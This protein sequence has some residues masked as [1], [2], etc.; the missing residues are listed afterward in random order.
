MFVEGTFDVRTPNLIGAA[1]EACIA[2]D[3]QSI[4][5]KNLI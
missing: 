2:D 4:S 3:H 5:E 1:Q